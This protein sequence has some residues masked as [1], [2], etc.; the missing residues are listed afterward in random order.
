[1]FDIYTSPTSVFRRLKEKPTWLVPMII[2]VV[3]NM[4][5]AV[6]TT[7][8]VDWTAQQQKAVEQMRERNMSEEDI[9]KATD[10]MNRIFGNPLVRYGGPL[11]N[12]LFMSAVGILFMALIYNICLPML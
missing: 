9:Q 8:Y 7:Q 11:V 12:G 4:V 10:N 6:I 3:L 5:A 1:M 2:I